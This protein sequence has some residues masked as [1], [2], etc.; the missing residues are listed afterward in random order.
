LKEVFGLLDNEA[1]E[2]INLIKTTAEK[3]WQE[4]VKFGEIKVLDSPYSEF[5]CTLQLDNQFNVKLDY[6]RSTLSIA[7]PNKEGY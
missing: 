6:D 5:E 3:V 1:R 7:V 4:N 2:N